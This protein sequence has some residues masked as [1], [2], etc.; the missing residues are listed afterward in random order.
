MKYDFLSILFVLSAK[1]THFNEKN[2]FDIFV[3]L[4]IKLCNFA[5]G[6]YLRI[7]VGSIAQLD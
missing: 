2:Y 4:Q 6:N 7:I 3:T 5:A 1:I